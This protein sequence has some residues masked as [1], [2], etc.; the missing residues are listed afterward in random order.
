MAYVM[1]LKSGIIIDPPEETFPEIT[2]WSDSAAGVDVQAAIDS[3]SSG[4]VIGIPTGEAI[5]TSPVSIPDS[6][7]IT[8]L[9]E[10]NTGV[11]IHDYGTDYG[12]LLDANASGSRIVNIGFSLENDNG[13]CVAV[14][15]AGWRVDHCRF[16]NTREDGNVIEGVYPYGESTSD[17]HPIGLIDNNYF[18]NTRVDVIG[19]YSNAGVWS[20]WNGALGL[21]TNN[22]V[23]IEDNIFTRTHGNA[24]DATYAGRFVARYNVFND[25]YIEAH[26]VQADERGTRSWEIYNNT[27]NQ[28]SVESMS[29]FSL[30]GGTGVVF[31]N[32]ITGT[33]DELG[34]SVDNVR[35]FTDCPVSGIM[36]GSNPW[37]GNLD[38]YG[39][40]GRDQI[41]CG[42]DQ[43]LWTVESPYPVQS[44]IPMYQWNNTKSGVPLTVNVRNGCSPIIVENRD[45]YNGTEKPG[46]TPYTYPHPL[47]G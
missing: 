16:I 37:D 34:V 7:K 39:W 4:A 17:G 44:L 28:V 36:T 41:G 26:S 13:M 30:R 22:A 43:T 5:W 10:S 33:W 12:F 40:P 32:I 47:R 46:Y 38:A 21:G 25:C 20:I 19:N 45:Y 23:F 1:I 15:G 14:R 31:N 35:F 2:I 11:I 24:I 9:G 6:K 8:L 27:I 29:P 18:Y 42:Q 3:S